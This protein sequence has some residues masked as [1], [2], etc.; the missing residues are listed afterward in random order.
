MASLNLARAYLL[1]D[2]PFMANKQLFD[3]REFYTDS[4]SKSVASILGAYA[5]FIGVRDENGI[6]I[7]RNRLLS[8]VTMVPE[9]NYQSFADA[10]MAGLAY[11]RL[12]FRENAVDKLLLALTLPG[13]GTWNRQIL[14]EMGV[15]QSRFCRVDCAERIC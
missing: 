8:A 9:K 13:V 1:D 5:R 2:K 4:E 10:Y 14:F 15:L 11:E 12:G 7:A 6:R 3:N